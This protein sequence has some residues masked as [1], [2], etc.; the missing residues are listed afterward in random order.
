MT[1]WVTRLI[2]ANVIVFFL[3]A[4]LPGLAAALAYVPAYTAIRPWTPFTYMFA[5]AGVGHILFNML[6]LYFF[7][8]ML[9]AR[10]GSRHFLGLYLASGLSGALLSLV[11]SWLGMFP[12]AVPIVGASGAVYGVMVGFARFWPRARVLVYGIFPVE[13]WFLILIMIVLTLFGTAGFGAPGVAHFA[14]LGGAVGGFLYLRVTESHSSAA[15]FRARAAPPPRPVA[16]SD[17]ERWKRIDRGAMHPVNREEFDRL[18]TKIAE[19]GPGSLTRD[20]RMF[21]DRF[22][23]A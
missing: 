12:A 17:L 19:A 18:M 3:T 7:G 2:V 1:P 22:T 10:L 4:A 13:A 6:S 16:D 5:H 9:E 14:H 15:R 8:P 20:E 23:P 11:G 21:L